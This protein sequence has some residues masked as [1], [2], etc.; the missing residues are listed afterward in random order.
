MSSSLSIQGSLLFSLHMLPLGAIFKKYINS[1]HAD[2]TQFYLPAKTDS[3]LPFGR[4][5]QLF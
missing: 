1:Y 2:D 3:F 4:A 5:L